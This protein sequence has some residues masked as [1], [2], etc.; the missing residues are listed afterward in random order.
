MNSDRVAHIV[1]EIPCGKIVTYGDI[2][3]A[4]YG[5]SRAGKQ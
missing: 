1:R 5:H 3:A 4:I 2:S